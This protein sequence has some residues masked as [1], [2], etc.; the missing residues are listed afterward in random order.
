[1]QSKTELQKALD[2]AEQAEQSLAAE[3]VTGLRWRVAAKHGISDEDAE[4]FL[5]GKDEDALTRQAQRLA[6]R[7][8]AQRHPDPH[9]GRDRTGAPVSAADQFA[10]FANNL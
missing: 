6:D 7:A 10:N 2:R 5:T 4:L 9:Q 3:Q 1:E 8:A